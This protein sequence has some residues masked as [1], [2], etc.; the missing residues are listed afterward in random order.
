[1]CKSRFFQTRKNTVSSFIS[2]NIAKLI[3]RSFMPVS[4]RIINR[5]ELKERINTL[6]TLQ[7]YLKL[8]SQLRKYY[9]PVRE[10]YN[11]ALKTHNRTT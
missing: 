5:M 10:F 3:N 1:M 11:T 6:D 8:F 4:R 9:A 2:A 7:Y